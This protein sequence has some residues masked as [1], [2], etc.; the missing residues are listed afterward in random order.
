MSRLPVIIGVGQAVHRGDSDAAS[1][2]PLHLLLAAARAAA[3]DS[4][5]DAL[6][7]VDAI[8]VM[9]V[10][11][12]RYDDL[13]ALVNDRLG[14]AAPSARRSTA[15]FSGD[16]PLRALDAAASRIA[17]GG[18]GV[19]L[20]VGAESTRA[21]DANARRGVV[22]PWTVATTPRPERTTRAAHPL[23]GASAV[24]IVRALDVFPLYENALRAHEGLTLAEAQRES[25][26][27]WAAMSRVAAA[28]D[29]AWMRTPVDDAALLAVGPANRPVVLPY[30]KLLTANPFVNQAAAVLV[31]D[32]DTARALGVR[33]DR[34]VHVLGAA[35]ADEPDDPRARVAYHRNPALAVALSAVQTI[36]GTASAE[37]DHVELY[38]C[39]PAMP[40][41]SAR[42]LRAQGDLRPEALTVTGGLTFFGG[43]GSNFMTHGL[44]SMAERLRVGGGT[45]LLHGVG[46]FNTRHHAVVL[47]DRPRA[48]GYTSGVP[49]VE[50]VPTLPAVDVVDGYTGPGTI[51][52]YG[53]TFDREGRA[54][55]G[56][57]IGESPGAGRFAAPV[58]AGDAAALAALAR[59]GGEPIG[60]AGSV[61]SD[62]DGREFRL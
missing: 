42:V 26:R 62:D 31:A 9:R 34:W 44:A 27:M 10:G 47:A 20:I 60:L 51:V 41:L 58:P 30:T 28:N 14:A 36:T 57:V 1:A 8:S 32:D 50:G 24:G 53:V 49:G 18:S 46:M 35:G 38:S 13:P 45:G 48:G 39:F 52:T 19:A 15:R 21:A 40:K 43:P 56:V 55:R 11:S 4:G 22:P 16:A 2:E 33:E 37:Y 25:A 23:A 17:A 3:D 5:V 59:A 54:E 6:P 29:H 61:T 7:R 12:W